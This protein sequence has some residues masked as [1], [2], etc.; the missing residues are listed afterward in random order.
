LAGVENVDRSLH[1][2]LN[3]AESGGE[4]GI[5][6]LAGRPADRISDD[7]VAHYRTDL[8]I[9]EVPIDTKKVRLVCSEQVVAGETEIGLRA[10]NAVAHPSDGRSPCGAA[11]RG[12]TEDTADVRREQPFGICTRRPERP[13]QRD[14]DQ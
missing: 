5:D 1:V 3:Q 4:K 7:D 6:T 2:G 14:H 8:G 11:C 13:R 9:E 10:E 12:A